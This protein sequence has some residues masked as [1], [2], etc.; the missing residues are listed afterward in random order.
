MEANKAGYSVSFS[1][2]FTANKDQCW[3]TG[4]SLHRI[5]LCLAC[6]KHLEASFSYFKKGL[7]EEL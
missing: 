1:I 6:Y 5:F 2:G 7:V 3:L 4:S